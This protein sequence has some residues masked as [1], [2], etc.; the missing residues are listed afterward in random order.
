MSQPKK[1][2]HK[3]RPAN[4][5]IS[6]LENTNIFVIE[7]LKELK[8]GQKRLEEG[9]KK[10]EEKLTAQIETVRREGWSQMRW[11]IGLVIAIKES[12][13]FMPYVVNFIKSLVSF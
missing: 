12:P 8:D 5:R 7:I 4:E 2:H 1:D 10:L 13:Y 3:D 9:Q 11:I 6:V